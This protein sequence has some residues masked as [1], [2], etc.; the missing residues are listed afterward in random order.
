MD[1]QFGFVLV[2]IATCPGSDIAI[3]TVDRQHD[4]GGGVI[5]NKTLLPTT[6]THRTRS[7]GLPWSF[8]HRPGLRCSTAR[9]AE[10]TKPPSVST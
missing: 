1:A 8:T 10:R 6:R 3:Q 2:G 5:E 7:G 9:I 4:V